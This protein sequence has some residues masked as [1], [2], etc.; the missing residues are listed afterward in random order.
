MQYLQK[1]ETKQ[2]RYRNIGDPISMFDSGAKSY[3]NLNCM[4]QPNLT[5]KEQETQKHEKDYNTIRRIV[6]SKNTIKK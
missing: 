3:L 2:E 5:H 4:D 6:L 1:Y